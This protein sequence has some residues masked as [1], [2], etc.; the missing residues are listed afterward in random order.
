MQAELLR[1]MSCFI[2]KLFYSKHREI[3]RLPEKRQQ[4]VALIGYIPKDWLLF[5]QA[6]M[7]KSMTQV[8]SNGLRL[9]NE[10]LEFLGD[11]VLESIISDFLYRRFPKRSEGYLTETRAALVKRDTWNKIGEEMKL[12]QW[13]DADASKLPVD[14]NGNVLEALIGAVYYDGGYLKAQ[15]FVEHFLLSYVKLERL[16]TKDENYKSQLIELC[17]KHRLEYRFEL[18]DQQRL[19]DNSNRFQTF[20]YI[21]NNKFS[22]GVGTTKRESEQNA[23]RHA[24]KGVQKMVKKMTT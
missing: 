4:L 1:M 5:E 19:A 12:T 9:N 2:K 22:E 18:I 10:R 11:A 15:S 16:L 7:L 21:G 24:I 17:Q 23:A 8:D 13:I 3:K 20:V 6:F 14:S